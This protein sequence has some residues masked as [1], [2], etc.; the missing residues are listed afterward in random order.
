MTNKGC[1]FVM[2]LSHSEMCFI[3]EN[4]KSKFNLN[5]L[6][7]VRVKSSNLEYSNLSLYYF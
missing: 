1:Y 6:N 3:V 2:A 7:R 5:G 4:T